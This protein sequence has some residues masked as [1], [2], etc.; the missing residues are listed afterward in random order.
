M[1]EH[2]SAVEQSKALVSVMQQDVG[3]CNVYL[4]MPAH[5][6]RVCRAIMPGQCT[7][8]C[9]AGCIAAGACCCYSA[10]SNG[11]ILPSCIP[12]EAA[13]PASHAAA[14]AGSGSGCNQV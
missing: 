2:T 4:M 14:A 1:Q 10:V 8:S 5:C 3:L 13:P 9:S 11:P 7:K 6:H 12:S